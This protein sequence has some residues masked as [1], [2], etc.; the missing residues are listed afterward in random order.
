MKAIP[1]L[2]LVLSG[3]GIRGVSYIGVLLELEKRGLLKKINEI[4]GVSCGALIGFAYSIGYMPNELYEFVNEFDFSLIQN[5]EPD[6][7]LYYFN[8]YGID[9]GNNL[10]RLLTS[11]LKNKGFSESIT[12]LELYNK[13]RIFF[14][15][16][17]T[18]IFKCEY[19][20]FSYKK[21]PDVIAIDGLMASMSIPGYF[22]PR[23][24][25]SVMYLDGC[26]INSFP[27]H[28]LNSIEIETSLGIVFNNYNNTV[29]NIPDILN[30]FKQIYYCIYK[31]S[32]IIVDDNEKIIRI[33][34]GSYPSW[35]F[36]A[37]R[38]DRLELINSG[39]KAVIDYYELKQFSVKPKRR[40]SVS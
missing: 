19:T 5:I 17:A 14:R 39:R 4:L 32:E 25:N 35:N 27:F 8:T 18:N 16:F 6:L 21:T 10:E 33:P 15:C 7:L 22:V 13:T 40:Y 37:S 36:S 38:D 29:D 1:P 23:T 9:N 34:C 28:I 3:G 11:M 2:R 12:Y 20:E 31:N 24:I 30:Y 26:I